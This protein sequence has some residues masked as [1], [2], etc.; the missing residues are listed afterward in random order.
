[1][2]AMAWTFRIVVWFTATTLG[3]A[4]GSG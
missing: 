1:M 4:A 2:V 3:R